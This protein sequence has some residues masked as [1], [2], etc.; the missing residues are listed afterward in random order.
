VG[1]SKG[2]KAMRNVLVAIVIAILALTAAPALA[3]VTSVAVKARF[4]S[5]TAG[6]CSSNPSDYDSFC[7]SLSC[8]CD[9]Y[10]GTV[11]GALLGKGTIDISLTVDTGAATPS[12]GSSCRPFFGVAS[13]AARRD[14]ETEDTTGTICSPFG[15]N[16]KSSVAGGFGIISSAIGE[17]G[18]GT[19]SGT[20]NEGTAPAL[21]MIQLR[22]RVTP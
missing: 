16:Q 4:V 3:R 14:S 2:V 13:F 1:F 15:N 18:W 6:P 22:A 20:L 19:I 5:E 12:S 8:V 17:S 21:L 7:P 10:S 11:N 9:I